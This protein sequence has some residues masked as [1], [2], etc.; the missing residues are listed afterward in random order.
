M[1]T[2]EAREDDASLLLRMIS[3]IYVT[4]RGFAFARTS[5][6]ALQ[7]GKSIQKE[8]FMSKIFL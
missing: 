6:K 4:I 7:Q 8:L 1:L 3:D 2:A 5:E